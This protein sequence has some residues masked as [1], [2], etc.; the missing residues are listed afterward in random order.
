MTLPATETFS[1]SAAAITDPPWT[2]WRYPGVPNS[3]VF[4]DGS[5]NGCPETTNLDC[6]AIWN[7]DSPGNDQYAQITTKWTGPGN[8]TG[9]IYLIARA[10]GSYATGT[11]YWFW[12]DGGSDC[13]LLKVVGN[14]GSPTTL[15]T[16]NA[17]TFVSGDVFK[18]EC[19]GTTIKVYKNGSA[20]ITVTDSAAASGTFGVGCWGVAATVKFDTFQ[21]DNVA[22]VQ[23]EDT[24]H[25]PAVMAI[26][27]M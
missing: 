22:S 5:G 15:G 12:C 17:T 20:I 23:V 16:A 13:A 2:Q 9:Y 18:L 3:R 19:I 27:A 21:G 26:L 1:G 7:A 25:R 8:G 10:T 4:T 6:F 11:Y 14:S 24:L